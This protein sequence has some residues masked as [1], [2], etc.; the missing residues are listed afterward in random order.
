HEPTL[1]DEVFVSLIVLSLVSGVFSYRRWRD[2][3]SEMRAREGSE[4][5]LRQLSADLEDRIAARTEQ[6]ESA[7]RELVREIESRRLVQESASKL[8]LAVEQSG[9]VVF[10]TDPEGRITFVNPAF[11]AVYGYSRSEAL[12]R[13]PRFL[14]SGLL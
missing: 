13:N 6:L 1:I 4:K 8:D 9:N 7:N 10:M 12:G 11:T 3:R 14:K 2:M 5:A